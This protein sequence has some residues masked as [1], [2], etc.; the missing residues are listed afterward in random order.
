MKQ[1]IRSDSTRAAGELA[2]AE[3]LAEYFRAGGIE[4]RIDPW[5]GN[6]A[7]LIVHVRGAGKRGALLFGSHLDVVPPGETPWQ[8]SPFEPTERDGR[9]YGRG[10]ADMKAGI[11]AAAAAIREIIHEGGKLQ[12][13]LIL[14]ATAGEESDS[15]GVLRWIEEHGPSLPKLSGVVVT[16]PT[17]FQLVCAHRGLVWIEVTTFGK[18]AHASMPHLGINAIE[19][20]YMLLERLRGYLPRHTPDAIL[21]EPTLS[22]NQ[23][24]GGK[25]P[26]VVPDQ[27]TITIDTRVVPGQTAE[28]IIADL[29][30]LFSELNSADPQ[31]RAEAKVTRFCPPMRTDP[32]CDFVRGIQWAV[33]AEQTTAVRYTTDGPYFAR[34]GA[35]VVVFGPG[36]SEVCHKP[37]EYVDI[38]DLDIGKKYYK[39][40]LHEFL[41]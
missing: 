9:I 38:A 8:T 29:E 18:T 25:A 28:G 37:D 36:D 21:G 14:A 19:Q 26:N 2:V 30:E 13:D 27:C 12:G 6:R 3:A 23:I 34:L 33:E 22:V 20:M 5:D 11:A 16:E 4:A 7:N 35:P 10:A 41:G 31:F 32:Q 40:I 15:C 17:A 1:L 39:A 24:A